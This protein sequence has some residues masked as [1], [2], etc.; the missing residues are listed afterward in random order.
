MTVLQLLAGLFLTVAATGSHVNIAT[1]QQ[2]AHPTRDQQDAHAL[3]D[4]HLVR[5]TGRIITAG[6][7]LG[8]AQPTSAAAVFDFHSSALTPQPLRIRGTQLCVGWTKGDCDGLCLETAPCN[9]T[10][11]TWLAQRGSH[12]NTSHLRTTSGECHAGCCV[13]FED[14]VGHFQAFPICTVPFGNQALQL[15]PVGIDA[16]VRLRVDFLS[17]GYVSVLSTPVPPPPRPIQKQPINATLSEYWRPAFHPTGFG[18]LASQ[19]I[20]HLQDPS[21]PFQDSRGIW[22]VFPDCTPETWNAGV[23]SR[24]T[25]LAAG[26]APYLGMVPQASCLGTVSSNW[27]GPN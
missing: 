7:A 17:G 5:P 21:A 25:L 3:D 14:K 27:P 2:D 10:S 16:A 20:G 13:D 9:A 8:I 11:P 4:H 1:N 24:Y 15:E 23:R 12:G 26:K 22:H 6:Q 19:S 18:A